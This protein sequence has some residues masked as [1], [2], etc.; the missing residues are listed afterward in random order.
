MHFYRSYWKDALSWASVK[1]KKKG[2]RKFTFIK[3]WETIPVNIIV[4]ETNLGHC[5][6]LKR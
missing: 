6:V 1:R 4:S 3:T 2:I 5:F